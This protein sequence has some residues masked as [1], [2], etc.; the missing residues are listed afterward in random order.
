[1]GGELHLRCIFM[2]MGSSHLQL[3]LISP[4]QSWS[5][6]HSLSLKVL[7]FVSDGSKQI[8]HQRFQTTPHYLIELQLGIAYFFL[9]ISLISFPKLVSLGVICN[10]LMYLVSADTNLITLFMFFAAC[11]I[12]MHMP[13][14]FFFLPYTMSFY[15]LVHKE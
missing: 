12:S 9:L 10:H 3:M 7:T 6:F 13:G 15:F 8:L 1:M 14:G 2:R 11:I 5:F 4:L